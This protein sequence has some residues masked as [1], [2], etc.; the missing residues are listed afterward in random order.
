M[1][2][3]AEMAFEHQLECDQTTGPSFVWKIPLLILAVVLRINFVDIIRT[4]LLAEVRGCFSEYHKHRRTPWPIRRWQPSLPTIEEEDEPSKDD[5]NAAVPSRVLSIP[6]VK[7][8]SK[9]LVQGIKSADVFVS[10]S[11]RKRAL[12]GAIVSFSR[13]PIGLI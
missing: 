1:R 2:V 8:A 7:D 3:Q 4:P 12:L 5:G 10:S 6:L 11:R 9:T 13:L